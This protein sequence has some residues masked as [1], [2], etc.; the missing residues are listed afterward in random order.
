MS[1][2]KDRSAS[3]TA[4]RWLATAVPEVASTTAGD[5]EAR[6]WPR[7]WNA[8]DRSSVTTRV[9]IPGCSSKAMARAAERDP[10]EMTT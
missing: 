10:G 2:T 3:T 4:G 1:G 9:V 5:P 6:A 8:A 7:A